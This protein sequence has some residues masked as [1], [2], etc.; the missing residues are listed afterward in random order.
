MIVVVLVLYFFALFQIC[1][2]TK[3]PTWV[4]IIGQS[5]MAAAYIL[6]GPVT[7]VQ[8]SL[9][10]PVIY[11]MSTLAGLGM[12]LVTVSSFSRLKSAILH[13]G[14][15]DNINTYLL[16]SGKIIYFN[17]ISD[18]CDSKVYVLVSGMW[19]FSFYLGIFVGPTF[20]GIFVDYYGFRTTATGMFFVC[21][22]SVLIDLVELCF[23]IGLGKQ[24]VRYKPL[25]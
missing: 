13:Q 10:V 25:T 12:G 4:S 3:Y 15:E 9:T 2:S 22:F 1:D 18:K 5:S 23:S 19:T 14:F 11:C 7:F 8:L 6:I 24:V 17:P 20:G 21:C 16:M